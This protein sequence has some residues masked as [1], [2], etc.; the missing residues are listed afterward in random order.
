MK[1][2]LLLTDAMEGGGAERQLSYLAIELKKLGNDVRLIQFY[3]K[4]NHY[5]VDLKTYGITT[6]TFEEGKT[7]FKRIIRIYKIVKHWCPDSVIC[8]KD[9]TCMSACIARIFLKFNLIVSERNTTQQLTIKER[10]KFLLYRRADHIVPNSVSQKHFIETHYPKLL[11]KTTV[12][13]NM[14]DTNKFLPSNIKRNNNNPPIVIT[15]ARIAPQKNV[16]D[17]LDVIKILKNKSYSI[18]FKWFGDTVF[19]Q[20]FNE[21]KR[22][23]KLLGIE[24]MIEFLPATKDVVKEYQ[25]AD[26]FILPSKYEGFPNVLC[27]AMA[28]GLPAIATNVCDSPIILQDSRFLP[29]ADSPEQI[30]NAIKTMI[31]LSEE[32]KKTIKLDN[33]N[34]ILKMCS[35][36]SFIDAYTS[37]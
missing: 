9:G 4:E 17:Y 5:D 15:T 23:V 27:E 11:N 36:N 22:K 13:T 14:I 24:D 10:I 12:I 16:L 21:V 33:R 26:I 35:S 29:S 32:E 28:C 20:Y 25:N 37:L 7:I 30:A 18:K 8:Y 6:E 19:P 2:Y 34:K 1:K 3:P 31:D